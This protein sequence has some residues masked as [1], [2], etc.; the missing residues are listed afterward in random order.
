MIP[1]LGL[2]HINQ[3][4]EPELSEAIQRVVNSGWYLLGVEKNKFEKEFAEYIGAKHCVGV[5]NGLDALTLILMAMKK[6]YGWSAEREVIVPAMTFI[7]SAEAIVRAGLTPC[8]CDVDEDFL[9]SPSCIEKSITNKTCAIMPVHLYGKT[10]DMYK[11]T[12]MANAHHLKVIEDAAQ[13]HGAYYASK[14]SGNWGDAAA[15]S[16]YPGKNLGALG[17]AGAVVTNDDELV[18][19]VAIIANYGAPQKY[20]HTHN[21]LNS[22]LDEIQAA[23][24]RVKL[25]YLDRDNN[26]RKEIANLYSRKINNPHITVPYNG[27][28]SDSVFHIYPV[29]CDHRDQL[30]KYLKDNG[31]ETLI[32]YP[33]P[34]HK[35]PVFATYASLSHPNAEKIGRSTLSLPISPIQSVENTHY[36]IEKINLF[37]L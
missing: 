10:C 7:A 36:I 11:I 19:E 33:T 20:L 3:T 2:K 32:H 29:Q 35:Q 1:F 15:F 22:R 8:F 14:K 17:D 5:A 34:L 28:T 27:V 31:I 6:K 24:L 18:K 21:G 37:Q 30:Q 13:A 16:F 23:V 4:Y 25:K 12:E 26:H 9:I